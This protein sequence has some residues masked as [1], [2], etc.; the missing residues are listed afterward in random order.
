MSAHVGDALLGIRETDREFR[1]E[2]RCRI[3][4]RATPDFTTAFRTR[5]TKQNMARAVLC[6]TSRGSALS[7]KKGGRSRPVDLFVSGR[8]MSASYARHAPV[9]RRDTPPLP[10]AVDRRR[11]GRRTSSSATPPGLR[12]ACAATHRQDR[13]DTL[14]TKNDWGLRISPSAPTKSI[15]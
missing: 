9:G 4:A 7:D 14:H 8:L 6:S 15:T 3:S 13:S 5:T 11:D 12:L 10:A 2:P 1:T